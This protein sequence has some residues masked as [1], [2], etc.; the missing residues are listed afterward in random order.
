MCGIVCDCFVEA[1]LD[2]YRRK[3]FDCV[4]KRLRKTP[5]SLIR[6]VFCSRALVSIFILRVVD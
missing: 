4:L 5:L 1:T 3:G 6:F 2:V